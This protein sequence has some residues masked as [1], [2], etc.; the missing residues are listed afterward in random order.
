LA[1]HVQLVLT[2]GS[3]L[4]QGKE[5]AV[6]SPKTCRLS[7]LGAKHAFLLAGLGWGGMPFGIVE[8][9]IADGRLVE[10]K[11]EDLPTDRYILGLSAAYRADKP[12]EDR[13]AAG[14]SGRWLID[15]L[16]EDEGRRRPQ[17]E[18]SSDATGPK[19]ASKAGHLARHK[20]RVG[21]DKRGS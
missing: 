19:S 2:D 17:S 15:R 6:F 11:L 16:K 14:P 12:P 5:F 13:Q 1:Q 10:I 9:D 4:S 7:D 8:R 3:D 18:P 20:K 21:R